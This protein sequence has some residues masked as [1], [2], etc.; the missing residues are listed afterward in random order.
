MKIARPPPAR[1]GR[2][3]K[4]KKGSGTAKAETTNR[5][6]GTSSAGA[7]FRSFYHLRARGCSDTFRHRL[8][9]LGFRNKTDRRLVECFQLTHV[10]HSAGE[11]KEIAT[12]QESTQRF[13]VPGF[14]FG[15][16]LGFLQKFFRGTLGSANAKTVL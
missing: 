12:A 9:Y 10:C 11:F 6:N 7:R 15:G 5:K 13:L 1:T 14:Q 8:G 16:R 4:S 3:A 2:A